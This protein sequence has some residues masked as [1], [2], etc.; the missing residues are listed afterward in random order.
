MVAENGRSLLSKIIWKGFFQ[1]SKLRQLSIAMNEKNR[2]T[3]SHS[4]RAAVLSSVSLYIYIS[5]EYAR[6]PG[7]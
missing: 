6:T 5:A 7:R 3:G 1:E 4:A 2:R